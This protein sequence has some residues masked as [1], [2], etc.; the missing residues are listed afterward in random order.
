MKWW[1][2]RK[3]YTS[4]TPSFD[5]SQCQR[6]KSLRVFD[7]KKYP[8]S[9]IFD[10]QYCGS[11]FQSRESGYLSGNGSKTS[12]PNSPKVCVKCFL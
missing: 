5:Q 6:S 12:S 1:S 9:Q 3:N 10:S 8:P 7:Q 4:G 2:F 11:G